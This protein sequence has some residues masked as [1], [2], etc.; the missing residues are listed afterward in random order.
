MKLEKWVRCLNCGHEYYLERYTD[1]NEIGCPKC[2]S[3]ENDYNEIRGVTI[4]DN[5]I[6]I[7][8]RMGVIIK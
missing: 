5:N 6:Y 8:E 1:K 7:E 4:A 2:L 3:K